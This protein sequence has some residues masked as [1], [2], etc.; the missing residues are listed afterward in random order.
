IAAP[1]ARCKDITIALDE[2]GSYS[3]NSAELDDG[4]NAGCSTSL[5]TSVSSFSCD[6]LGEQI[7][8]LTATSALGQQATCQATV[9]VVDTIA[10]T[11]N[12][13]EVTMNTI[14]QSLFVYRTQL[15]Q[16]SEDNCGIGSIEFL[17]DALI[18]C[19]DIGVTQVRIEVR[20]HSGNRDTCAITVTVD[21]EFE[22][23]VAGCD[24]ETYSVELEDDGTYL[25]NEDDLFAILRFS[26]GVE[27]RDFPDLNPTASQALFTCSSLGES[28]P[29]TFSLT[30]PGQAPSTCQ[31]LIIVEDQI[32]PV[33][34]TAPQLAVKA[35][36][37]GAFDATTGLMRDDLR[38]LG[39]VPIVDP[40]GNFSVVA[41]RSVLEVTGPDAIVDW[42]Q[43]ELRSATDPTQI[44]H[45]KSVLLQRDGDVVDWDGVSPVT[46][47]GVA[48]GNYY[49]AIKH[50]NHLAMMTQTAVTLE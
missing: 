32:D 49:V 48:A 24:G 43:L 14:P 45:V 34:A 7:V 26:D 8:T 41:T 11:A 4:S 20:D 44:L 40:Y 13:I 33:C 23:V 9:T 30:E 50:R 29:V 28:V 6:D 47:P 37:S 46:L 5:S 3:L 15:F 39:L 22:P 25:L 17:D 10:P 12:C 38:V 2:T 19:E 21:F 27:C 35:F 16:T 36:L 1:I 18:D 42:V 31:A